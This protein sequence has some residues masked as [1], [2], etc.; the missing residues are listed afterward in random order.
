[1]QNVTHK[2]QPAANIC[3]FRSD[4]PLTWCP[5]ARSFL[6]TC[7]TTEAFSRQVLRCCQDIVLS[8]VRDPGKVSF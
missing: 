8:G 4:V 7:V 2:E 1:M 5:A 3:S 6:V